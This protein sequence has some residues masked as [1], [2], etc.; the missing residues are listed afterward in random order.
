MTRRLCILGLLWACCMSFGWMLWCWHDETRAGGSTFQW[1]TREPTRA[2]RAAAV[3][4]AVG[5]VVLAAT[6]MEA[7]RVGTAKE[8]SE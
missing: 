6:L 5:R 8:R 3:M 2:D 1:K 4:F 7:I